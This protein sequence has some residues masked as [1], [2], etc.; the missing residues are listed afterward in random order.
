MHIPPC[1]RRGTGVATNAVAQIGL[2]SG[3]PLHEAVFEQIAR[4]QEI[5]KALGFDV[6][7]VEIPSLPVS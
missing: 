6:S 2:Y 3:F 5:S 7:K 4:L 1:L